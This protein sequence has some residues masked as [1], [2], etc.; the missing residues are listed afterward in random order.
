MIS[1]SGPINALNSS[2]LNPQGVIVD[3]ST[4]LPSALIN[5]QFPNSTTNVFR[6]QNMRIGLQTTLD[7][8]T[9]GVF[10]FADERTALG[11]PTA[12]TGV[13]A[14]SSGSD[15]AL[16]ANFNW[17]RSVTPYLTSAATLGYATA[18]ASHS[19]TLTADLSLNYPLSATLSAVLHYQ[20]INV[21]SAIVGSYRRN[22]VEIGVTRSF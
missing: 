3:Q 6:N 15:T 21:D 1:A 2:E 8:D 18:R 10:G 14:I 9:Y 19:K 17:S 20:F 13:A 11:P 16:G 7:R 22:Q 5:P 4:G 12:V